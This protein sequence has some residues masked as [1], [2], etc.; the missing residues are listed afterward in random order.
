MALK[1]DPRD[2]SDPRHRRGAYGEEIAKRFL[3]RRG[4]VIR[5]HRFRV[6]RWEVDLVAE[7]AGVIAFVEVKTRQTDAFGS[8]LEAVTWSKQREIARVAKAWTDRYGTLEHT[9]RFDV[10]GVTLGPDSGVRS[11]EHVENAFWPGWR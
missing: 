1:S 10:I 5:A 6:G 4:W 9:I 7:Q 8:P 11:I 2:W 3:E